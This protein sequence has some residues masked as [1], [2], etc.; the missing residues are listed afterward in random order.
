VDVALAPLIKV[1]AYGGF[2]VS[3][4]PTGEVKEMFPFGARLTVTPPIASAGW[5]LGLFAGLGYTAVYT[6]SVYRLLP[7]RNSIDQLVYEPAL[8]DGVGGG[9]VEI[10]FGA[11]AS[12]H[13]R[14][15]WDLFLELKAAVGV[16]FNG[17]LYNFD[18]DGG[19]G[20]HTLVAKGVQ[21]GTDNDGTDVFALS[22][23]FGFQF[24]R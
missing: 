3:P 19:R 10:P 15:H 20:G 9:F 17:T 14:K 24:D 2:E 16:G 6:H 11:R 7:V 18:D 8:L 5:N 4:P 1:G 21:T 22:L 13:L 23:F 12:Y